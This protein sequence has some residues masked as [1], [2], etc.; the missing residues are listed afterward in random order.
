M[1]KGYVIVYSV[2]EYVFENFRYL[3]YRYYSDVEGVI[4]ACN[5]LTLRDCHYTDRFVITFLF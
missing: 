3:R 1:E 2:D 4:S 5:F